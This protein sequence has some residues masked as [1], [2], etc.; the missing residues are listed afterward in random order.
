MAS[1]ILAASI[2]TAAYGSYKR[3]EYNYEERRRE[4]YAASGVNLLRDG[5]EGKTLTVTTLTVYQD[6]AVISDEAIDGEAEYSADGWVQR[7]LEGAYRGGGTVSISAVVNG[8]EIVWVCDISGIIKD[9]TGLPDLSQPLNIGVVC[10]A[11]GEDICRELKIYYTVS[12]ESDTATLETE[13]DGE[14]HIQAFE[15][16]TYAYTFGRGES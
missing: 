13:V 12:I 15:Y 16:K 10:S 6:G 9:S 4:L 3:S 7:L 5:L 11:E 1:L 14:T 2:V 8:N